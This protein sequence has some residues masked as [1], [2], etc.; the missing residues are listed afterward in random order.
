[1][2]NFFAKPLSHIKNL[3]NMKTLVKHTI[4]ILVIV[5]WV[6]LAV[7]I[8][9]SSCTKDKLSNASGHPTEI[10]KIAVTGPV[11]DM[12]LSA[13]SSLEPGT[14]YSLTIDRT[15]VQRF[16]ITQTENMRWHFDRLVAG[17]HRVNINI[18]FSTN[19]A[20]GFCNFK[21]TL[22][23]GTESKTVYAT[24]IDQNNYAFDLELQ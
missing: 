12:T 23:N 11:I 7:I 2:S 5:I 18:M 6:V 9:L 22:N 13:Y 8:S 14:S 16:N 17:T 15:L 20:S 19:T 10:Q 24:K 21:F 3:C 1:M 4:P